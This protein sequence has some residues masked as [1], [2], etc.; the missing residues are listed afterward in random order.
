M[1]IKIE[2]ELDDAQVYGNFDTGEPGEDRAYEDAIIRRVNGGDVWA[3]A[4]VRVVAE[5]D[6]ERGESHWLGGCTYVDESDFRACA[7]FADLQREAVELLNKR[8]DKRVKLAN[9]ETFSFDES[10]ALA[11][12][13]HK[14]WSRD[15]PAAAS[16]WRR[17]FQ[18]STTV[19]EFAALVNEVQS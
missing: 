2:V 10:C 7:Y 14:R 4:C 15:M 1:E 18:N 8:L 13:I 5:S 17:L 19:D 6:G 12:L 16:A 9:G 3:W 11:R